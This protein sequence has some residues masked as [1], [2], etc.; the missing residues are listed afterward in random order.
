M[1]LKLFNELNNKEK[2]IFYLLILLIIFSS[3]LEVLSFG[4]IMPFIT[5]LSDPLSLDKYIIFRFLSQFIDSRDYSKVLYTYSV[6]FFIMILVSNFVKILLLKFSTKFTYSLSSKLSYN[7]FEKIL[8][9]DYVYHTGINSGDMISSI[10]LKVTIL[11]S[12]LNSIL[13]VL[14]NTF[15]VLVLS[16]SLLLVEPSLV[17]FS[18]VFVLTVYGML[19]FSLKNRLKENSNIIS[20]EQNKMIRVIQEGLGGIREVILG[21]NHKFYLDLFS[22]SNNKLRVALT[23]NHIIGHSPKI[24]MEAVLFTLIGFLA[25]IA[26]GREGGIVSALPV[27]GLLAVA[28]QRLLP[29]VQVIY[30]NLVNIL[31]SRASVNEVLLILDR[32]VVTREGYTLSKYDFK[33]IIVLKNVCFSYNSIDGDSANI[34]RNVNLEIPKGSRVG[35][36]GTTGSGKSTL[37]D[38][39]IGL[40]IPKSGEVIID[41]EVLKEKTIMSWQKIIAHVPQSIFLTDGTIAQ[42]VAFGVPLAEIDFQ[43]VRESLTKAGLGDFTQDNRTGVFLEVGERG[44]RLSGGQKQRIGIARALYRGS[45]I[46]VFDEA[47]SALD[48]VTEQMILETIM[49]LDL[50]ITVIIIAH[51][52]STLAFCDKIFRLRNGEID[53]EGSYESLIQLK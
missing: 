28:G 51:R 17:L 48:S 47:T 8:N 33:S 3:F 13:I 50:S 34:L 39:I 25:L 10:S 44:V 53:F 27:I 31:A 42:N 49:D 26:N 40:L 20:Q 21:D 9:E 36:V 2:S 16:V 7:L 35:F 1:Y 6:L 18:I 30:Q 24:V 12:V 14:T 22:S 45:E 37:V 5:S 11:T 46:L 19:S 4:S 32:P 41:N 29:A 15:V 23:N 52:I 43:K 38:L